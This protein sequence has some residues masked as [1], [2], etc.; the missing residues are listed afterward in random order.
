MA[1]SNLLA[2]KLERKPPKLS[3]SELRKAVRD[4]VRDAENAKIR[5]TFSTLGF[6]AVLVILVF[7]ALGILGLLLCGL[8]QLSGVIPL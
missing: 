1:W 2:R 3:D 8:R 5:E 7:V 4:A 6:L